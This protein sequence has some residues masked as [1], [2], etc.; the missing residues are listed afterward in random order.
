MPDSSSFQEGDKNAAPFL[1][2]CVFELEIEI[3]ITFEWFI[4]HYLKLSKLKG[5]R[6]CH[7]LTAFA[8]VVGVVEFKF[9]GPN[10]LKV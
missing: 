1:I 3:L 2:N 4:A 8:V 6:S 5:P 9:K 10:F 7:G